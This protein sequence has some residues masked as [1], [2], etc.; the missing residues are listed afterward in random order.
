MEIQDG[1]CIKKRRIVRR[2]NFEELDKGVYHCFIQQ[3]CKGKK[4]S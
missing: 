4:C 2:S 1:D 3:R